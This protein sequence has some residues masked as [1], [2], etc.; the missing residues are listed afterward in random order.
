MD[1]DTKALESEIV[2][3]AK[4]SL[5]NSVD[6]LMSMERVFDKDTRRLYEMLRTKVDAVL[7]DQ[8]N[9]EIFSEYQLYARSFVRAVFAHVEGITFLMRQVVLWAYERKEISLS[10]VEY[11]KL[12]EKNR[13]NSFRDNFDL[14][15]NYFTRLFRFAFRPN[16]D[17]A[18]W[19]N[20][21]RASVVR[22]SIA[23]PK[24]P[25]QFLLSG[26][27]VRDAQLGLLWFSDNFREMLQRISSVK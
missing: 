7:D 12:S 22:D 16:K 13:F 10:E 6:Y 9:E 15:F 4:Q 23:H 18:R 14:A 19:Q 2:G 5:S 21:C 24:T 8:N 27:A 26:D 1:G 20:F 17:D 11:Q 3:K 25:T